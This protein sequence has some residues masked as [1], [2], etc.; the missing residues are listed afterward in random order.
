MFKRNFITD[1]L[2]STL[3]VSR[4]EQF[5][6]KMTSL[7]QNLNIIWAGKNI[8]DVVSLTTLYEPSSMYALCSLNKVTCP[9]CGVGA[10]SEERV[11]CDFTGV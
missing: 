6:C 3:H 7:K 1:C 5:T 4:A 9:F 10:L 8:A 2:N 11:G